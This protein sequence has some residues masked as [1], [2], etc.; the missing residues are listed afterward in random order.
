ME[1]FYILI[2]DYGT[3]DN[4]RYYY[5]LCKNYENYVKK[6]CKNF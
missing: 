2:S 3:L 6:L 5:I 1:I 4:F